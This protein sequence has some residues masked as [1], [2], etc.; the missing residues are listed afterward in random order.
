MRFRFSCTI[1]ALQWDHTR[2]W[3]YVGQDDG[4]V[5]VFNPSPEYDYAIK[6]LTVKRKLSLLIS[7][8]R[9][10]VAEH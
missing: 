1:T 6:L 9:D 7:Q 10:R 8:A 5:V 3:L 2:R 4:S